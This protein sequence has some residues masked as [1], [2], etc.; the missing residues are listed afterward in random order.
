[1]TRIIRVDPRGLK[2]LEKNA[3]FMRHETYQ[4]LIANI[5]ADG[6]LESVPL[7]CLTSEEAMFLPDDAPGKWVVLSGNHRTK[8]AIDA[9]LALIDLKVH[10]RVLD[11]DEFIAKQLSHNAITGEDDP[12]TLKALYEE[13]DNIDWRRYAGL[14]DKAL[15]LIHEVEVGAL[16]EANLDFRSIS[17]VMLPAEVERA[18]Q[19]WTAARSMVT[20]Q[21]TWV[22]SARDYDRMLDGLLA[23]GTSHGVKNIATE[24]MI[25]LDVFD[26]YA[27]EAL[28]DGWF[29]GEDA[30]HQHRVPVMTV[31]GSDDLPAADGAMILRAVRH[32]QEVLRRS[33]TGNDTSGPVPVSTILASFAE[34]YLRAEGVIRN[35]GNP[36][37]AAS[38][39]RGD[40]ARGGGA[41]ERGER[42]AAGSGRGGGGDAPAVSVDGE[43][44]G[45]GGDASDGNT[46]F[47]SVGAATG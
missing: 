36:E 26:R 14:D 30:R 5:K 44:A 4:Q 9:G 8:A 45:R 38:N 18:R 21:E 13:I 43:G 16:G 22:A 6:E 32:R 39:A 35:D 46:A 47:R 29:D 11:A 20:G 42:G 33:N 28:R 34:S 12:A 27:P 10:D 41:G 1:M 37:G 31:F 7:A 25:M 23:S 19:A 15:E 2:L 17:L 24:L 40:R 3:R